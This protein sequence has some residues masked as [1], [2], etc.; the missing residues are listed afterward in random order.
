ML[1]YPAI[2]LTHSRKSRIRSNTTA[3]LVILPLLAAVSLSDLIR[4]IVLLLVRRLPGETKSHF[5]Q[6]ATATAVRQ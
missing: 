3:Y 5:I 2:T 4:K 1:A 6:K